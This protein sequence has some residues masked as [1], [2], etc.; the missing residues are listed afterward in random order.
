MNPCDVCTSQIFA[1]LKSLSTKHVGVVVVITVVT[2]VGAYSIRAQLLVL[3]WQTV[4]TLVK[5]I[6]DLWVCKCSFHF[7]MV[8]K[9]GSI[10][11]SDLV[12]LLSLLCVVVVVVVV[13]NYVV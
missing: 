7:W 9:R 3:R 1:L 5:G 2:V 13:V 12:E 4:F 10:A 11:I 8:A 6:C